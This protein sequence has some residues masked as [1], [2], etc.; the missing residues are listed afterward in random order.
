M[1]AQC[2]PNRGAEMTKH[3]TRVRPCLAQ[4]E[5]EQVR[6]PMVRPVL[7][8]LEGEPNGRLLR[9]SAS[10]THGC[11]RGYVRPCLLAPIQFRLWGVAPSTTWRAHGKSDRLNGRSELDART[12]QDHETFVPLALRRTPVE[13]HEATVADPPL[14]FSF[15][16]FPLPPPPSLLRPGPLPQLALRFGPCT[17]DPARTLLCGRLGR[18]ACLSGWGRGGRACTRTTPSSKGR[19]GRSTTLS[20]RSPPGRNTPTGQ[21]RAGRG[22]PSINATGP[23]KRGLVSILL[24]LPSSS[25]LLGPSDRSVPKSHILGDQTT[26]RCTSRTR[27]RSCMTETSCNGRGSRAALAPVASPMAPRSQPT[28]AVSA[29]SMSH[30]AH[31]RESSLLSSSQPM[32]CWAGASL[33][34]L[35]ADVCCRRSPGPC[36]AS[37]WPRFALDKQVEQRPRAPSAEENDDR[38]ALRRATDPSYHFSASR[39]GKPSPC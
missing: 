25:L 33:L 19:M 37:S 18:H 22:G 5:H 6:E 9:L 16:S 3:W 28:R 1:D 13:C 15:P 23:S 35:A 26:T 34:R 20:T 27:R 32:A 21:E 7:C 39:A 10:T 24:L 4:P 8:P 38:S 29:R 36:A 17:T 2:G 11:C 12:R 30:C 14:C 31:A